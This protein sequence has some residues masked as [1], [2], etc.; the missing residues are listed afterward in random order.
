M[1]VRHQRPLEP[2][3]V[4]IEQYFAG[5]LGSVDFALRE[6]RYFGEVP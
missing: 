6:A 1:S 4:T 5:N 3:I 2:L